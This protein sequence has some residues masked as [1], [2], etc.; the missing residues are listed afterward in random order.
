[1]DSEVSLERVIAASLALAL[2]GA[3]MALVKKPH[4][5]AGA[6]TLI[7]ALGFITSIPDL[8]IIELAVGLLVIQAIL[9]NRAAAVNKTIPK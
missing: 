1:M 5:P 6:T 2:T 7:I 9:S 3:I 8:V 4:A